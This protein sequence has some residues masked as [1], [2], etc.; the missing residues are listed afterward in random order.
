MLSILKHY[1]ATMFSSNKCRSIPMET[2]LNVSTSSL[3]FV[4]GSFRVN[5]FPNALGFLG[6]FFFHMAF[7]R[8][9]L[10]LIGIDVYSYNNNN[11]YKL[12]A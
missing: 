2:F 7:T 5:I 3:K 11:M 8:S 10:L 6:G 12:Y 1:R 9:A 4:R